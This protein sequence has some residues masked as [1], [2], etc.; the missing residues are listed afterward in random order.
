HPVPPGQGGPPGAGV[1][2]AGR[3]SEPR[4]DGRLRQGPEAGPGRGAGQVRRA[5]WLCLLALLAGCSTSTPEPGPIPPPT[6]Q[7]VPQ[8]S[9]TG[10]PISFPPSGTGRLDGDLSFAVGSTHVIATSLADGGGIGW[11]QVRMGDVF[12]A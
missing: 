8:G 6:P 2:R 9:T 3:A 7:H 5:P 10:G 11:V 1:P 12:A 4:A